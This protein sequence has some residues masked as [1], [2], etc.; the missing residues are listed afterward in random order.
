MPVPLETVPHGDLRLY[1]S[2]E[3]QRR[4]RYQPGLKAPN[5]R[6][7]QTRV[8][9]SFLRKQESRGLEEN[10]LCMVTGPL[11]SQG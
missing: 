1:A 6:L 11:L 8:L 4:E 10:V 3:R 9:S 2:L 7:Q 5:M